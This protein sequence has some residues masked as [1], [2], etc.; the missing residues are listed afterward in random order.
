MFYG[1]LKAV[2]LLRISTWL[3]DRAA[4]QESPE[5][6]MLWEDPANPAVH[7]IFTPQERYA[8]LDPQV[9]AVEEGLR[10][11]RK[12]FSEIRD[13]AAEQGAQLLVALIPTKE[14]VYCN[15][16]WQLGGKLPPSYV[17]L[18]KVEQ[19]LKQELAAYLAS[20]GI[21]YVDLAGPLQEQA[22]RHVPIYP[23]DD[24]GHPVAAGY[25]V[26]AKAIFEALTAH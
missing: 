25:A 21:P 1:V 11:T 2:V 14:R 19:Q 12:A 5:T 4:M 22:A 7:T 8:V 26:I 16:L 17:G 3:K 13:G 24:D 15:Y 9:P 23:T 18:C 20:L 10:I 6:Q